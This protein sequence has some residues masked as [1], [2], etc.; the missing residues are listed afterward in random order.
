M[1]VGRLLDYGRVAS[2]GQFMVMRMVH[3]KLESE[4]QPDLHRL[5]C[6]G[7]L[8]DP[9]NALEVSINEMRVAL[10][11]KATIVLPEEQ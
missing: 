1:P 4:E 5:T 2:G 7:A 6:R 11:D 9:P 8:D 3:M 10:G